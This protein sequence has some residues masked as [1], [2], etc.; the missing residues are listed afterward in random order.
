[1]RPF[2]YGERR[3]GEVVQAIEGYHRQT[4]MFGPSQEHQDRLERILTAVG[5]TDR[6]WLKDRLLNSH[7]PPLLERLNDVMAEAGRP[8]EA[9]LAAWPDLPQA[10]RDSRNAQTHL[11]QR[12]D[13]RITEPRRMMDAVDMLRWALRA[14]LLRRLGFDDAAADGL[15]EASREFQWVR[16]RA[17]DT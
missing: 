11:V 4:H 9:I 2:T 5:D 16:R 14:C 12:K 15:L 10:V 8:F 6:K 17:R 13:K 3:F 1:M 7:E